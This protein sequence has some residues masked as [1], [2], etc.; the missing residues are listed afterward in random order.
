MKIILQ[1][2]DTYE[3]TINGDKDNEI[4]IESDLVK[5]KI[6]YNYQSIEKVLTH[7]SDDE[8]IPDAYKEV[9][10]HVYEVSSIRLSDVK[11][12]SMQLTSYARGWEK[13]EIP[14][15]QIMINTLFGNEVIDVQKKDIAMNLREQLEKACFNPYT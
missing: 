15:Y 7:T 11:C 3:R 14:Y 5:L 10:K 1:A 12:V 4:V 2:I 9:R 6:T 13:I 8:K